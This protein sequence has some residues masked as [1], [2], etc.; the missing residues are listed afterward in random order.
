M[1]VGGL[2]GTSSDLCMESVQS[3][4]EAETPLALETSEEILLTQKIPNKK[5]GMAGGGVGVWRK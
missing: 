4:P 1:G 5:R 2:G 3:V